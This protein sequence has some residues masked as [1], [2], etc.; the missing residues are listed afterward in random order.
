M[1][2]ALCPM[3]YALCPIVPHLSLERLYITPQ[4]KYM[5]PI[6]TNAARLTNKTVKPD[7]SDK[8]DFFA[9]RGIVLKNVLAGR[10]ILI[11][12]GGLTL[13]V[14]VIVSLQLKFEFPAVPVLAPGK[15]MSA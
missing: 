12:F 6:H 13:T 14:I 9:S 8:Y 11:E 1:P 5:K 15:Q 4:T 2:Y 3:P 7:S 10:N